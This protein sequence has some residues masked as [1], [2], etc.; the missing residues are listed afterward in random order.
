MSR[1]RVE[2]NQLRLLRLHDIEDSLST[3]SNRTYRIENPCSL[4][5]EAHQKQRI[6]GTR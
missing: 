2:R 1:L 5:I 6:N 4:Q 3:L